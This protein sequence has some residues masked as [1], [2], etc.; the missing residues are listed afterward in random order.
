LLAQARPVPFLMSPR[1]DR[2]SFSSHLVA[3]Q[4]GSRRGA[5][6]GSIRRRCWGRA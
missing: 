6:R 1:T 4:A 2:P 3:S 5:P